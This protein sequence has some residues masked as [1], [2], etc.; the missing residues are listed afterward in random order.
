MGLFDLFRGEPD[1]EKMQANKD[2]E[3]LIKALTHNQTTTRA[4]AA[5]A[6]GSA[7]DDRAIEPLIKAFNDQSKDVKIIAAE[8]LDNYDS[9]KIGHVKQQVDSFLTEHRKALEAQREAQKQELAGLLSSLNKEFDIEG[10]IRAA[11]RLACLTEFA[12]SDVVAAL[13]EAGRKAAM[14]FEVKRMT[15]AAKH[16]V[17]P[18]QIQVQPIADDS[19]VTVAAVK[20]LR[21][22]GMRKDTIG[23]R[24]QAALD[25]LR[26]SIKSSEIRN[27][28]GL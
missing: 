2:V 13:S 26:S 12:E 11:E 7:R 4:K 1:V 25:Q 20:S 24:A 22:L 6:L 16:R 23:S 19:R 27:R 9:G 15:I 8:S 21:K 3:G 10:R 14:Q 28:V 5:K 17:Q 18:A